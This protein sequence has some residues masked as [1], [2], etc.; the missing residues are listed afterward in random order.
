MIDAHKMTHLHRRVFPVYLILAMT[1]SMA[2]GQSL[3]LPLMSNVY[4]D[5]FAVY[6]HPGNQLP[7]SAYSIEVR[8][9]SAYGDLP[10]RSERTGDS[11]VFVP[12]NDD[13]SYD[14]GMVL[15]PAFYP[16]EKYTR[17]RDFILR[18][19][20][21]SEKIETLKSKVQTDRRLKI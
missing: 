1:L 19:M 20:E 9:T 17:S 3:K 21:R 5:N 14:R 4:P 7:A 2:R 6:W 13:Y 10:E 12:F 11:L 8:C 16:S 18:V 15:T